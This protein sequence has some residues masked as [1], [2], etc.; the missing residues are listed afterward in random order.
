MWSSRWV[1][2]SESFFLD[3]SVAL[4]GGVPVS[5]VWTLQGLVSCSLFR[6]SSVSFVAS[7]CISCTVTISRPCGLS[8]FTPNSV[9]PLW[10]T[11]PWKTGAQ[12]LESPPTLYKNLVG[13]LSS[14]RV[15]ELLG[16][17]CWGSTWWEHSPFTNVAGV[18]F[19]DQTSYVGWV[20]WF[21]ILLWEVFPQVLQ[22][23][24]L[25]KKQHFDLICVDLVWFPFSQLGG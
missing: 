12:H 25:T 16:E 8:K 10:S 13:S 15:S 3:T 18:R 7:S 22:F 11:K 19:S 2:S 21:S 1:H 17:Q 14:N 23:F 24:P 20:C 5:P 9:N 6:C 4:L